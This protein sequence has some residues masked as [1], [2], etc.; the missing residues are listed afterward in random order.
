MT[1]SPGYVGGLEIISRKIITKKEE[2]LGP[3]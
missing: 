3:F 1:S 2:L